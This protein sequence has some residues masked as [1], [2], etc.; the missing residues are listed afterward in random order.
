MTGAEVGR[1]LFIDDHQLVREALTYS[2]KASDRGIEV[3]ES[4]PRPIHH[5]S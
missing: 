5:D 3:V 2:L 1:I 4:S